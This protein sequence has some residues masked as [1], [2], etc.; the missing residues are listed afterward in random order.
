MPRAGL[1]PAART[2]PGPRVVR[3]LR[4]RPRRSR[5]RRSRRLGL[6]YTS[7]PS[8]S[9]GSRKRS[10]ILCVTRFASSMP[11]GASSRMANSSPKIRPTVAAWFPRRVANARLTDEH[12]VP[13]VMA[14]RVVYDLEIVQVRQEHRERASSRPAL[15]RACLRRSRKEFYSAG[16]SRSRGTPGASAV[17]LSSLRPVMSWCRQTRRWLSLGPVSRIRSSGSTSRARRHAGNASLACSFLPLL[18]HL[19]QALRADL[20]VLRMMSSE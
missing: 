8:A 4:L 15:S 5:R 16:R 11:A 3:L 6:T 13:R 1:T 19:A 12:G 9:K 17:P 14:Q 2:S 18:Q 20:A 7:C 10:S